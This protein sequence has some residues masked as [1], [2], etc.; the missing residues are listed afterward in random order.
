[1]RITNT[2]LEV[3]SAGAPDRRTI[4]VRYQ[5]AF[6]PA[7]RAAQQ[8]LVETVFVEPDA[9]WQV[10]YADYLTSYGFG[11]LVVSNL[12]SVGPA[13]AVVAEQALVNREVSWEIDAN[14]LDVFHVVG[15]YSE[16]EVGVLDS[17]SAH[18]E[19]KPYVPPAQTSSDSNVVQ[20][21]TF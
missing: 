19:L 17:I 11:S 15:P 10:S 3:T 18:V 21:L 14:L 12:R 1:M 8:V 4:T 5:V 2:Q 6:T 20:A 7:E 9:N 16:E 13:G